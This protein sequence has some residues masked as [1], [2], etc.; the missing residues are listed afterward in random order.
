M[1]SRKT[2]QFELD[3]YMSDQDKGFSDNE[4]GKFE[5]AYTTWN[6]RSYPIDLVSVPMISLVCECGGKAFE[7]IK[8]GDYNTVAECVVCKK[9]YVVHGG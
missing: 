3:I 8:A 2:S 1:K 4:F 9:Y 5:R 6:D 7:V